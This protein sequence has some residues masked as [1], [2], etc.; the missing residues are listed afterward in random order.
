MP[1]W[2]SYY[3]K[4]EIEA[5]AEEYGFELTYFESFY[6]GPRQYLNFIFRKV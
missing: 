5:L 2:F 4:Q 3:S 6:P 1:R